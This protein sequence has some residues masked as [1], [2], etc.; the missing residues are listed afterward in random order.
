[1]SLTTEKKILIGSTLLLSIFMAGA[2]YNLISS[3]FNFLDYWQQASNRRDAAPY[4]K[5]SVIITSKDSDGRL[6]LKSTA[7]PKGGD[8]LAVDQ[9]AYGAAL[10]GEVACVQYKSTADDPQYGTE[11]VGNGSCPK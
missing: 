10:V 9:Y 1:M 5:A 3:S 7:L 2:M 8:R 6:S 4:K 11:F